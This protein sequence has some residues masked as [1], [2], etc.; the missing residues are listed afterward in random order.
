MSVP[1]LSKLRISAG[2]VRVN[3]LEYFSSSIRVRRI[4]E[5]ASEMVAS[6][7]LLD[8]ALHLAW[9]CAVSACRQGDAEDCQQVAHKSQLPVS[10]Q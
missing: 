8:E 3:H 2:A 6:L 7:T 9:E 4:G 1:K 5:F 10:D